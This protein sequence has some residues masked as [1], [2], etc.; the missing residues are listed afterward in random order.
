MGSEGS[1]RQTPDP[2]NT[3]RIRGRGARA[4]PRSRSKPHVTKGHSGKCGGYMGGKLQLLSG[5]ACRV[6]WE[7]PGNPAREG[8]LNLQES[9]EVIVPW[10][11]LTQGKD[12]TRERGL[13][14]VSSWGM[15]GRQPSW[16]QPYP[17][18][19]AVK[20][21]GYAGEPSVPPAQANDE[22]CGA[23]NDL[24]EKVLSREGVL[25][26]LKRVEANG[27]APG[28]GGM[29]TKDLRAHLR[30]HWPTYRKQLLE[31]TY[32]PQPVRRVEIPKQN[33]S[34]KRQLGIPTVLD[35]FI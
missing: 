4:R 25:Q 24:R 19:V 23:G 34:G 28:V 35:R 17:Q 14:L 26:A 2:R 5:E 15:Q 20:P 1:W 18:K 22:A 29:E 10:G 9:A 33:G 7:H 32:C 30:E 8:R 11:E 3:D 31:G 16:K 6:R 21:R 12:R 27:G 13:I